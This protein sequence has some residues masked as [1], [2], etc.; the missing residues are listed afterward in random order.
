MS[1][2]KYSDRY[3]LTST[4]CVG[5]SIETLK[6]FGLEMLF[7]VPILQHRMADVQQIVNRFSGERR[8]VIEGV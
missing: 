5:M 7:A 4:H 3:F 8:G 1:A 6:P 2:E